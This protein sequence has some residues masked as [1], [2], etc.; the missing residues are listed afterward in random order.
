MF[1]GRRLKVSH[2]L[3]DE[4]VHGFALRVDGLSPSISMA[5]ILDILE[6]QQVSL[7]HRNYTS[8]EASLKDVRALL[9]QRAP[10]NRFELVDTFSSS[11]NVC[12][13]ATY[14]RPADAVEARARLHGNRLSHLGNSTL[15]VHYNQILLYH[16]PIRIFKLVEESLKKLKMNYGSGKTLVRLLCSPS[17]KNQ[18]AM[19]VILEGEDVPTISKVKAELEAV[20]AGNLMTSENGRPVWHRHFTQPSGLRF[21]SECESFGALILSDSKRSTLRLYG[22]KAAQAQV[23]QVVGARLKLLKQE[24]RFFALRARSLPYMLKEGGLARLQKKFGSDVIRLDLL[25]KF[26]IIYGD[27]QAAQA[28][29]LEINNA[30]HLFRGV[31]RLEPT[32]Q[33]PACGDTLDVPIAMECGHCYCKE[34]LRHFLL[35]ARDVVTFP[36]RCIGDSG[37]CNS[38][39]SLHIIQAVLTTEENELLVRAAFASYILGHAR[40]LRYCPTPNCSQLYRPAS[41]PDPTPFQCPSCLRFVCTYCH[42]DHLGAT[43]RDWRERHDEKFNL[44]RAEHDVKPCPN[45]SVNIDRVDGCNHLICICG[46]HLCWQC[47]KKFSDGREVYQHMFREHGGIGL[48]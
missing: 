43:C 6:S 32:K 31:R 28:A 14:F 9:E 18:G 46:T 15:L 27:P 4:N 24:T 48:A 33:C 40:E 13:K 23:R 25:G 16:V 1:F 36:L 47:L 26:L 11:Q 37:K 19:C 20:L 5:D 3:V 44:W 45:C 29:K 34:C 39:L 41:L 17:K 42:A 10:L 22:P 35:S 30:I 21:L 7:S 12:V 8:L 38:L 2:H